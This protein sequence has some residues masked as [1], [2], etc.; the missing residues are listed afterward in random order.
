ME[1]AYAVILAGGKGERF[2]PLS[3]AKRP[4]QL[5]QLIGDRTMLGIAIDRLEGLVPPERVLVIT[6]GDIAEATRES[7]AELPAKNII[8]EPFG[9]DTAAAVA[10][11]AAIVKKRDP[12]GVFCILTADH[13][14]GE[15]PLFRQTLQEAF[16]RASNEEV[17]ITIGIKPDH[18]NTGY[19]YVHAGEESAGDGEIV[20]RKALE[21]K[22]KPDQETAERYI[23]DGGYFWN[24]GMFIWS[25]DAVRNGLQRFVPTLVDMMDAMTPSI[26][27]DGFAAA[28][29][30]EYGKLEKISVDY[31]LMEKSDNILMAEGVFA[32]DDVGEWPAIERHFDADEDGN[33]ARGDLVAVDA[34]NN[35]VFSEGRLTAVIGVEDLVVVQA[36]GVT[37]VCPKDRAQDV[38]KL[39]EQV[40]AAGRYEELL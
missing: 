38:K 10:L 24:S 6:N 31:A 30:I 23:A 32:W 28:L 11:A 35:I 5:I 1:H 19:G 3:V 12:K 18:P 29:A 17:L 9:R 15:L 22:E 4:K 25:A 39:V 36:D 26:D 14:M 40:R 34:K 16:E 7:A 33:V 2:W 20:F 21:F 8:G 13:I 27:T 37:L